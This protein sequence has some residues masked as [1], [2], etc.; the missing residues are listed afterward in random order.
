MTIFVRS[1]PHP[2]DKNVLQRMSKVMVMGHN[3]NGERY[4]I[5]YPRADVTWIYGSTEKV[6][7]KYIKDELIDEDLLDNV[8]YIDEIT[9]GHRIVGAVAEDGTQIV[10]VDDVKNK[11]V[12]SLNLCRIID[13]DDFYY[14]NRRYVAIFPRKVYVS[15]DR[16]PEEVYAKS[17]IQ[18]TCC[19]ESK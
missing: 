13:G 16:L 2:D 19:A 14:Y 5:V 15:A 10:I 3:E 7:Q 9:K 1:P 17:T 12:S 6:R 18:R 11:T 8:T 4:E